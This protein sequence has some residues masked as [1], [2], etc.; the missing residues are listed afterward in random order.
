MLS[1]GT[2]DPDAEVR[3]V[4]A[5]ARK[6]AIATDSDTPTAASGAR[7]ALSSLPG[8]AVGDAM[9]SAVI[10]A[11]APTRMAVYDRRAQAG[12][13]ALDLSLSP[14]PGR[15]ARYMALVEQLVAETGQSGRRLTARQVD[16]GLYTLGGPES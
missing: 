13:E 14:K 8:F 9:A 3:T 4:T 6:H 15:Y 1:P 12:L 11:L 2:S 10:H 5:T 16:L 7:A